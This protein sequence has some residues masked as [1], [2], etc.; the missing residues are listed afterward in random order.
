[1]KELVEQEY[2]LRVLM[3]TYKSIEYIPNIKGVMVTESREEYAL[4][5]ILSI[6]ANYFAETGDLHPIF[7]SNFH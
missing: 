7:R 6:L 4:V 5:T 3:D 1:V 2:D